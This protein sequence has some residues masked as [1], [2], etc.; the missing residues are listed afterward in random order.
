MSAHANP[1]IHTNGLICCLDANDIRSASSNSTNWV[2]IINDAANLRSGTPSLTTISG[3]KTWEFTSATQYFESNI[4]D[5][6]NQPYLDCTLEAWIYPKEELTTGD[7]GTVIRVNGVKGLYMS[8]NK[9]NRKLSTYWYGHA[10]NG[11]H[12]TGA[13]M[14]RNQ[15]HHIVSVHKHD[16]DKLYQYTDG[17]KTTANGTQAD[18]TDYNTSR[19]GNYVEIGAENSGR[20]FAG[21]I[22]V[23]RIYNQALTDEQVLLNYNAK[24]G[25]FGKPILSQMS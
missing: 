17:V 18:S 19:S 16:D 24:C 23:V 3:A 22:A 7:R 11:Y 21:G 5:A 14:D 4:L 1:D 2:N 13:A 20:Q 8:W 12:E 10:T 25:L 9:S 15:W 6:D